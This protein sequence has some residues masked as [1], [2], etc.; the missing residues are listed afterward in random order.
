MND[1]KILFK[2]LFKGLALNSFIPSWRVKPAKH[3]QWIWKWDLECLLLKSSIQMLPGVITTRNFI[4][5]WLSHSQIP[6]ANLGVFSYFPG[7]Q[8]GN[9]T[10]IFA[11]LQTKILPD[12]GSPSEILLF[13]PAHFQMLLAYSDSVQEDLSTE[14][15]KNIQ[16]VINLIIK[17][18]L[19]H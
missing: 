10:G 12:V 15:S 5:Y 17:K 18:T 14:S 19:H 4:I 11:G 1:L 16:E 13:R 6:E 7:R 3:Y 9:R 8:T 2:M